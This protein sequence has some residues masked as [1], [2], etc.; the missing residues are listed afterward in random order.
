MFGTKIEVDEAIS[1]ASA[2]VNVDE[3]QQARYL[4]LTYPC[5]AV[6][7]LQTKRG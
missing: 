7:C 5:L 2:K 6:V 4:F 1:A 3:V